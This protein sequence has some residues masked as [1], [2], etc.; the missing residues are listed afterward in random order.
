MPCVTHNKMDM[1]SQ[2]L[3]MHSLHVLEYEMLQSNDIGEQ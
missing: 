2:L 3:D 1:H